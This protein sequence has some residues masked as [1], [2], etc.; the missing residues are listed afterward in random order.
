MYDIILSTV[1]TVT[2][3]GRQRRC[4]TLEERRRT[5]AQHRELWTDRIFS[6]F[7]DRTSS[8]RGWS[9]RPT[10]AQL[11]RRHIEEDGRSNGGNS[12]SGDGADERRS[13]VPGRR[14][15]SDGK[16]P[17]RRSCLLEYR[18]DVLGVQVRSEIPVGIQDKLTLQVISIGSKWFSM[19]TY[20]FFVYFLYFNVTF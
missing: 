2:R 20:I 19:F 5:D 9:T 15:G 1:S 18:L 10:A 12:E 8:V 4:Y 3:R 11:F 6:S 7:F 16:T 13:T 17:S 14:C